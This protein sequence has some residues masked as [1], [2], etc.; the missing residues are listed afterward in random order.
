M[1]IL[2]TGVTGTIGKNLVHQVQ[3]IDVNLSADSSNFLDLPIGKD[4]HLLHLAGMVGVQKCQDNPEQ[5][6]LINVVGTANLASIFAK[7]SRGVFIF[8]SSGHVYKPGPPKSTEDSELQPT[9]QYAQHK[10]EAEKRIRN[11]FRAEPNRLMILRVFSVLDWNTREGSLGHTITGAIESGD[12]VDIHN[13]EDIRDFMKPA[14]I[15]KSI[16]K[17]I[18]EKPQGGIFNLCSGL[19][20]TVEQAI[21]R[22][23]LERGEKCSN[24]NFLSGNSSLPYL[25]G[26]N[27]KLRSRY[28]GLELTWSTP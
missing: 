7:M 3:P 24:V 6:H 22:M 17:I 4:S 10:L 8:V 2:A 18:R 14:V 11:I 16:I 25:V 21:R 27:E 23:C 15:A 12:V 13:C 19:G 9:N 1:E 26:S 20:L 5:S 28:P